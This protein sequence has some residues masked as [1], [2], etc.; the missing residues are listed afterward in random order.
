MQILELLQFEFM[1]RAILG[2]VLIAT[3][4]GFMG[5]L[6][7][8][9]R[10]SFFADT[11]AHSSLTGVALGVLVGIDPVLTAALYALLLA[12]LMPRM[13][14]I[15]KVPLDGLLGFLLPFSMGLGVV[16]LSWLPGYR[17]ELISFLFGNI[18]SVSNHEL[19][20]VI[21]L[22][23]VV[24]IVI[25]Q[26]RHKMILVAFDE[27]E[28]KVLGLKVRSI[29]LW[30]NVVLALTIVAGIKLAGIV[31][32]NAL[33][34]IPA[35]IA[36]MYVRS[37]SEMFFITPIIAVT[38]TLMG[39]LLSMILNWPTGPTV[40]VLAGMIFVMALSLKSINKDK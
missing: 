31:L 21:A 3:A 5:V 35:T 8:L 32:I 6:M 17:P 4:C 22:V 18:L 19:V 27:I 40:A 24:L 16:I 33:L 25:F 10:A 28:A 30:F 15:S 38:L 12:L 26:F 11:I 7:V 23:V 9:K 1:Q 2:G 13:Q 39:I 29:E 34:V 36:R 14:K 20:L 37:L